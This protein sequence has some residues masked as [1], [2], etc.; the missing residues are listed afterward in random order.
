[1][2]CSGV[3]T[4][5]MRVFSNIFGFLKKCALGYRASSESY[6]EKLRSLGAEIGE[7]V[8]IHYPFNT[9]IDLTAPWLLKIGNHVNI[10]G[11]VTI[12]LH[13]YSWSVIKGKTGEVLGCQRPVSIGSN[14]F[15]GWGATVLCGAMIEDNVII[16]AN[17]V[18]AGRCESDSVYAGVPARRICSLEEYR[19]KRLD[20]QVTEAQEFVRRFRTR[21]NRNPEPCEMIEY[22]PVF[23]DWEHLEEV[24]LSQLR[25][26]GTFDQSVEMIRLS[27]RAYD[28]FESFLESC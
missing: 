1:M 10:T 23:S 17:S 27:K 26:M 7:D 3:G 22:F 15:I 13:D 5:A 25:L 4:I 16:G 6:I 8:T 12:L 11:P 24:H 14:V 2:L 28:S 21:F 19:E 9:R 18:V 20:S